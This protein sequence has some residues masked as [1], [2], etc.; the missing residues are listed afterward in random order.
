M[1][2]SAR[3]SPQSLLPRDVVSF[4]V[5]GARAEHLDRV[6]SR[7]VTRLD[8]LLAQLHVVVAYAV[9]DVSVARGRARYVEAKEVRRNPTHA[10]T[11]VNDRPI[12]EVVCENHFEAIVRRDVGLSDPVAG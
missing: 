3:R 4:R 9:K 11:R 8:E 1:A 6:G 5:G 10:E 7:D 2:A 12:S